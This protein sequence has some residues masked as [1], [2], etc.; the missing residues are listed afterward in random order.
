MEI[1]FHPPL[2]LVLGVHRK[3]SNVKTYSELGRL[4]PVFDGLKL[5]CDYFDW[6]ESLPDSIQVKKAFLDRKRLDLDW[7]HNIYDC[8]SLQLRCHGSWPINIAI[9]NILQFVLI[10]RSFIF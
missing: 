1:F 10:I 4:P 3:A 5:S 7:C 8:S 6:C 9:K 2:E